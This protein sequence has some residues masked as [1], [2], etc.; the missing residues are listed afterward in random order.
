MKTQ[1]RIVLLASVLL[2]SLPAQTNFPQLARLRTEIEKEPAKSSDKSGRVS[3]SDSR[4]ISARFLSQ[5]TGELVSDNLPLAEQIIQQWRA[6]PIG[7]AVRTLLDEL[8]AAVHSEVTSREAVVMGKADDI[9]VNVAALCLKATTVK[10]FD[11][12][13][14]DLVA[15]R[16]KVINAGNFNS[17][18]TKIATQKLDTALLLALRWQDYLAQKASGN[19]GGAQQTMRDLANNNLVIAVLPRSEFLNRTHMTPPPPAVLPVVDEPGKVRLDTIED[20]RAFLANVRTPQASRGRNAAYDQSL[21]SLQA[22]DNAARE[23]ARGDAVPMLRLASTYRNNPVQW[24]GFERLLEKMILQALALHL[25]ASTDLQPAPDESLSLYTLRIADSA[26]KKKD[27]ALLLRSL[28]IMAGTLNSGYQ[29]EDWLQRDRASI[30]F[31]I[32]GLAQEKAGEDNQALESYRKALSFPARYLPADEIAERM[33]AVR[34]R[35]GQDAAKKSP[36]KP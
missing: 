23:L 29:L 14:T 4:E 19:I 7:A 9:L 2:V 27:W 22:L 26:R 1:S 10:E 16:A 35:I 31:F 3:A 20:V 25:N 36:T 6:Q 30:G 34:L 11:P 13:L 21:A 18:G 17:T 5:L 32:A 28:D 12:V 8:E 33:K 15:Y 24:E